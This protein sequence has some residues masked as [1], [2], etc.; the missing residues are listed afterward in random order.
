MAI[1]A[2]SLIDDCERNSATI[3]PQGGRSGYW[4]TFNDATPGGVQTPPA[5]PP[6]LPQ[7]IPGMPCGDMHGMHTFGSGYTN[8]GAGIGFDLNHPS[9]M[10]RMV[11]DAHDFHGIVFFALGPEGPDGGESQ[12][13]QVQFLEAATTPTGGG[14][15]DPT[16]E[17]CQAHWAATVPIT[18]TGWNWYTVD[19]MKDIN[20]PAWG[21]PAAWDPST[22]LAIQFQVNPAKTFDFWV[23]NIAFY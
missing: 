5:G 20:Q 19:W 7:A 4:F 21:T 3:I 1:D 18:G 17:T 9:G 12:S 10:V 2:A 6:F 11:Y 14:K 16:T 23:D 15:C 13:V 8:F 22:L